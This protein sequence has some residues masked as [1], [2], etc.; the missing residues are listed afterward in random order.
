MKKGATMKP[1]TFFFLAI[2]FVVISNATVAQSQPPLDRNLI[3]TQGTAEVTG[4][5]DSARIHVSVQSEA[6]EM[7]NAAADNAARTD[8]VLKAIKTAGIRD[9]KVETGN[10]RVTPKKDFKARPP[11]IRGYEVSNEIE[12]TTEGFE[13]KEL[14]NQVSKVIGTSLESGA[15]R[16]RNIQFYIK[17]NASLEKQG[18]RM[19]TKE[20]VAQAHVLAEAAGVTLGRIVSISTQPIAVPL[21]GEMMRAAGMAAADASVEPPIESGES[22]INVRVSVVHEME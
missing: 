12:I 1:V 13:P 18:L 8:A 17:D 15:N 5:N 2:F 20:A 19:A 6:R 9:L 14:S 7:E 21:R 11:V 22:R 3:F 16:I 10:Y 4:Q